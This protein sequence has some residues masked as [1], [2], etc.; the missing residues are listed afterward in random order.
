MQ[1]ADYQTLRRRARA[2][3]EEDKRLIE[4]LCARRKGLHLTQ[5]D[6]AFRMGVSQPAVSAIESG[7]AD[8]QLSTIRRYANAMHCMVEYTIRSFDSDDDGEKGSSYRLSYQ[9]VEQAPAR[10]ETKVFRRNGEANIV[11][12]SAASES[13]GK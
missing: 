4:R 9:V 6:I 1:S 5:K 12:V 10:A 3:L 11:F 2:S 8:P 7:N 13:K